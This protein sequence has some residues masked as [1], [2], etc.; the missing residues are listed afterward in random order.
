MNKIKKLH[1][2]IMLFGLVIGALIVLNIDRKPVYAQGLTG[3]EAEENKTINPYDYSGYGCNN[4][5]DLQENIGEHVVNMAP[6]KVDGF[7]CGS[8]CGASREDGYSSGYHSGCRNWQVMPIISPLYRYWIDESTL[9][10]LSDSEKEQFIYYVNKAAAEWNS[11]RI[12]NYNGAIVELIEESSNGLNIVPVRYNPAL[13]G[14]LGKFNPVPLFYQIEIKKHNDYNTIMHEFGHMIGLQDLDLNNE[15]RTHIALMGY[16]GNGELHYQD[17]QGLAVANGKHSTHDYRRYWTENGSYN[18]VCFYCDITDTKKTAS[19]GGEHLVEATTCVHD[20]QQLVSAGDRHWH[21]C[22]KCYKVIETPFFVTGINNDS[23]I[24][25]K[26]VGQVDNREA[27]EIPQEIGGQ[28]VTHIGDY[29]FANCGV[30]SVIFQQGSNVTTIGENAFADCTSLKTIKLFSSLIT[31]GN[32]AFVGCTSLVDLMLPVSI[33]SVGDNAFECC[34]SL[35]EMSL[36]DGVTSI[37]KSLFKGCSGLISISMSSDVESIG[38]S[39]FAYCESLEN[40]TI[41]SPV[42]EIGS[43]AFEHCESLQSITIPSKVQWIGNYCFSN[44]T[45]LTEV[46]FGSASELTS[47][48]NSAFEDCTSLVSIDIPKGIQY[49]YIVTF[50]NCSALT[51]IKIPSSVGYVANNAFVGCDALATVYYGDEPDNESEGEVTEG[52]WNNISIGVNNSSL[53]SARKYYYRSGQPEVYGYFWHY[54]GNTLQKWPFYGLRYT[55]INNGTEY[56]ISKASNLEGEI[57]IP[58]MYNEKPVTRIARWGF[59]NSLD[60]TGIII[61]ESISMLYGSSFANCPNIKSITV[62]SANKVYMDGYG[63]NC[64]IT[65]KTQTLVVGCKNSV[66]PGGLVQI[67]S[68][69]FAGCSDLTNITIP[70]SVVT[71]GESAFED[72][73]GLTSFIMQSGLQTIGNN[74]LKNCSGITNVSI[75]DSVTSIGNYAFYGLGFTSVTVP[76]GVLSIGQNAFGGN[77]LTA[78][79]VD[80]GNTCYYSHGGVLFGAE[81]V[82]LSCPSAKSGNYDIP[83]GTTEI[84]DYAFYGCWQL[85]GI[86]IINNVTSIGEYAFWGCTQLAYITISADSVLESIGSS[87]F[88]ECFGVSEITIPQSVTFIGATAFG[89][90]T[91]DQTIV[92]NVDVSFVWQWDVDWALQCYAQINWGGNS[93]LATEGLQYTLTNVGYEVSVGSSLSDN[94]NNGTV[95][96]PAVYNGYP[97]VGVA[98]SGFFDCQGLVKVM[99]IGNNLMYIGNNAFAGCSN[100]TAI[101]IPH[102]VTHIGQEA[103]CGCSQLQSIYLPQTIEEIYCTAFKECD[104]LKS[105]MIQ[106]GLTYIEVDTFDEINEYTIYTENGSDNPEWHFIN[107]SPSCVVFY[108]CTFSVDGAFVVSILVQGENYVNANPTAPC[109]EGYVFAGWTTTLGGDVEYD[110]E[111]A[112]SGAI[113]DTVLYAVWEPVGE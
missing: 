100:L 69:A 87:A 8:T 59:A 93:A 16:A 29:A 7:G 34:T 108:N 64:I 76:G 83:D 91:E 62:N 36:P 89:D 10:S 38:D 19:Y 104:N 48:G 96:I 37:G 54:E 24:T 105:I 33:T 2:F 97:V 47:I 43:R 99:F 63:K 26:I 56:E 84:G 73:R 61:P 22:T 5:Y 92:M 42:T 21:K 78:I 6:E 1:V 81:G 107:F 58:S 109:R 75:P 98:E 52:D 113:T 86:T 49:I 60:I 74:A 23:G 57:E 9:T 102:G 101:N 35:T 11:V 90:W 72:C 39:A 20:Y 32:G 106:G 27:I 79:N 95:V 31:I 40:L 18:Y 65:R 25:L 13:S 44:C 12:A 85:T 50:C 14:A 112:V 51:S 53:I 17:I 111:D 4:G 3:I 45:G 67:G 80:T 30:K 71:I 103:F 66:L 46:V 82:L 94:D 70:S 28:A 77:N 55:L 110:M 68:Y 88:F 15:T 41:P